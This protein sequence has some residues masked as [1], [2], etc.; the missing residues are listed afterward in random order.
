[1]WRIIEHF[2]SLD[3]QGTQ[4]SSEKQYKGDEQDYEEFNKVL[5]FTPIGH[6]LLH[7]KIQRIAIPLVHLIALREGG[8]SLL[9]PGVSKY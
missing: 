5:D 4:R 7:H 3:Y 6:G 8:A 1:M 2:I 9:R